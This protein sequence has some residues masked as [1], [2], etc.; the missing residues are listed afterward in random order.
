MS[1]VWARDSDTNEWGN[2]HDVPFH[3]NGTRKYNSC[4]IRNV[5]SN[6]EGYSGEPTS[7]IDIRDNKISGAQMNYEQKNREGF[8]KNIGLVAGLIQNGIVMPTEKMI[9]RSV[10]K[11]RKIASGQQ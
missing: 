8:R 5:S 6:K 1:I 4:I 9:L 10:E 2:N 3:N 7:F 11:L